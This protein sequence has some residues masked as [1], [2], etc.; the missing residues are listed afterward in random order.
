MRN[1]LVLFLVCLITSCERISQKVTYRDG[2]YCVRTWT[3][4]N[5]NYD[6]NDFN[7]RQCYLDKSQIDSVKKEQLIKFEEFKEL[8]NK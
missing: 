6:Y 2:K 4:G 1:V 7:I 5:L 3:N 8:L